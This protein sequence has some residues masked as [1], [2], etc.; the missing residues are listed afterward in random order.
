[1]AP[2][3]LGVLNMNHVSRYIDQVTRA[4]GEFETYHWVGIGVLLIVVGLICM[5]GYGSQKAY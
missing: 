3:F 2:F 5:R 1:M 4:V